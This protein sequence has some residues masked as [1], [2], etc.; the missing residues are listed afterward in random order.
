MTHTRK[1]NFGALRR[2]NDATLAK[3]F[4]VT[5]NTLLMRRSGTDENNRIIAEIFLSAARASFDKAVADLPASCMVK[6]RPEFTGRALEKG[7]TKTL[8]ADEN[9]CPLSTTM[10]VSV[11]FA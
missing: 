6:T 1:K 8:I 3:K 7:P 2:C 10:S 9:G 5:L 4:C 11:S